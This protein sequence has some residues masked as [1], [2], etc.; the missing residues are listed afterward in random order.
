MDESE[1]KIQVETKTQ[2]MVNN[3]VLF[4]SAESIQLVVLELYSKG[5]DIGW[6][7]KI[8]DPLSEKLREI[9]N[10]RR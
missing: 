7:T 9:H 5:I 8:L 4:V 3:G 1:D 10:N 2:T 6:E